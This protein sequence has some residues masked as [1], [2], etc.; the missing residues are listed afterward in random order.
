MSE[1]RGGKLVRHRIALDDGLS[2]LVVDQFHALMILLDEYGI[3]RDDGERWFKLAHRLAMKHEPMFKAHREP[4]RAKVWSKVLLRVLVAYVEK[5][6]ASRGLTARSACRV[7][8]TTEPWN[9]LKVSGA[10]LYRRYQEA[11]AL[12]A[13]TE[14]PLR[15]T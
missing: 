10:T 5:L 2:L 15:K 7:L 4:G 12:A 6:R 9:E 13:G 11:T 14:K 3:A 8:S 1:R